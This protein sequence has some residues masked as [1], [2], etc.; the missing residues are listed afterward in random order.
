MG[1]LMT[2]QAAWVQTTWKS[3]TGISSIALLVLGDVNQIRTYADQ[4]QHEIENCLDSYIL[5]ALT[6]FTC[7][8]SMPLPPI[9]IILITKYDTCTSTPIT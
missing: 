1:L 8:G 2:P 7:S 3:W 4:H 6:D 5:C 9:P